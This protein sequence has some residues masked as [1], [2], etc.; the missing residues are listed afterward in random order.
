MQLLHE[1]VNRGN[2]VLIIEHNQDVIKQVTTS[3][4]LVQKV[5]KGGSLIAAGTPEAVA[6]NASHTAA[7]LTKELN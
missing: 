3:V 1:L 2:T 4:I 7:F 5:E 6:K